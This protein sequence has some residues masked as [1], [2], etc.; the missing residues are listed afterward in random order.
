MPLRERTSVS[1]VVVPRRAVDLD[2]EIVGRDSRAATGSPGATGTESN[3]RTLEWSGVDGRADAVGEQVAVGIRYESPAVCGPGNASSVRL[4]RLVALDLDALTLRTGGTRRASVAHRTLDDAEV[5]PP[6][7]V[8][9]ARERQAAPL[10]VNR[11]GWRYRW[12][13]RHRSCRHR[14]SQ[15]RRQSPVGTHRTL[16]A[17]RRCQDRPLGP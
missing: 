16:C 7:S 13:L 9:A 8:V 14:G 15:N 17:D 6:R 3:H 4:G 10:W 12:P 2:G 5:S 11:C 1:H